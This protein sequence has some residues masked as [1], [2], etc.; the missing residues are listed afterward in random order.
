MVLTDSMSDS[1]FPLAIVKRMIRPCQFTHSIKFII[2]IITS[3]I[4]GIW[5]KLLK[6]LRAQILILKIWI[7]ILLDIA[8]DLNG[9]T[10]DNRAEIFFE[11]IA[12]IQVNYLGYPGTMG[13]KSIDYIVSDNVVISK[14]NK[15]FFIQKAIGWALREVAKSN[16]EWVI[17]FVETNAIIG[18]AK[19]EALKHNKTFVI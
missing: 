4:S 5:N 10:Q 19:R 9:Y 2:I 15:E 14:S 3:F 11:R 13:S 8:I 6:L 12:P 18:L 17:N 16:A 1:I 7:I